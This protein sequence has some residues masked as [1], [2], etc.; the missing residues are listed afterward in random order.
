[1]ADTE[2]EVEVETPEVGEYDERA[3]RMGWRPKA[4]YNGPTTKWVD[5]KAFVERGE[6]EL[7]VL[8]ERFRKLDDRLASTERALMEAN[9]KTNELST[10]VTEQTD[11][12][13]ELRD[14]TRTA[15][16]RGREASLRELN[17]RER[18]AVQ[19]ADTAAYDRIQAEKRQVLESPPP[20]PPATK[21]A[22]PPAQQP[23]PIPPQDAMTVQSWVAENKWYNEDPEMMAVATSIHG[24]MRQ[25]NPSQPLAENLAEVKQR[26]VEL[27]PQKFGTAPKRAAAVNGGSP[28][29][30]RPKG[31]TVAD[32][33][34]DA[35]DALAKIKRQ[36]PNYTDKEYLDIYF[37]DE[38]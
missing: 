13:G 10:K 30:P 21:T 24:V 9:S 27:Y 5:A 19:E 23:P 28:P 34:A 1:M 25:Q 18:Q 16:K 22:P 33:P 35:K 6:Q 37:G 14:L 31:K 11:V 4:E 17:Q 8:R 20:A 7:P 26:I 3:R 12:L 15:E 2:T 29:A 36:I 38:A 32:L